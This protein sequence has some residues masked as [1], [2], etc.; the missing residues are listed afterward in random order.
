[1]SLEEEIDVRSFKFNYKY[2]VKLSL[3]FNTD[4]R[5]V[6]LLQNSHINNN[7]KK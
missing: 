7:N 3:G 2:K 1:M 5:L 6:K 4:Y